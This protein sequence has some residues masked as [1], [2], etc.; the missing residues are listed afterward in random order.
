[1]VPE[2]RFLWVTLTKF[3]TFVVQSI[4]EIV[5]E[6]GFQIDEIKF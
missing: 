3:Q 4:L 1:M 5:Q 2:L 6:E